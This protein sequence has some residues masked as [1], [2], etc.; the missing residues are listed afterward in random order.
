MAGI[1]Q[2]SLGQITAMG[3]RITPYV[4]PEQ[5]A[6]K[7]QVAR[8]F[9]GIAHRYDFLNHF[10]SLGIDVLWRKSCIRILRNEQP[11]KLLDVA[12]GTADFAIEA[13]RMGLDVHVTGVDISAGMLDVGREKIAV[14]GWNDRIELIQGDSVALPFDDGSFDGF[15]VAFGVRNFE[16]LQGGL[17]DMLRVLKPGAMGL[18]LEFSKPKHFPIK[19][20]FGLYFKHIMPT[21]GKW[22]SKDPAAYTYLPESVQAFPEGEAFLDEMSKAGYVDVKAKSLTGGIATIYTG[23]KPQA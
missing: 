19:Q 3:T 13:V 11:E 16:D 20:V 1:S 10:F 4:T 6:K 12:T 9:D 17:Q 2:P 15:T 14:R 22:V 8:M 23:R 7:N 21:V 5:E 18:V